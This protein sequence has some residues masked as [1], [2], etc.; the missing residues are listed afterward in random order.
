MNNTIQ[1]SYGA[2]FYGLP[3]AGCGGKQPGTQSVSF[4]DM[5]ARAAEKQIEHR[6]QASQL[7]AS[8]AAKS[9]LA[10]MMNGGNLKAIFGD[11]IAGVP[12]ETILAITRAQVWGSGAIL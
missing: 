5:A 4:L 12:T 10:S 2:G 6:I 8:I 7:A 3:A 1:P 11:E 9:Q